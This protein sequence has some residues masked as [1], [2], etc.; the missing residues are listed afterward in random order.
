MEWQP[1]ETAPKKGR[2]LVFNPMVGVYSSEYVEERE[3]EPGKMFSEC[4]LI[5]SGYPL[6]VN[7]GYL[8]KW[9]CVATLW[10][11]LPEAPNAEVRGRP[12]AGPAQ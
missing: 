3:D 8:G 5:W 4:E 9:Y 12:E 1:I 11:Q 2:I 10:R 7:C 6:G